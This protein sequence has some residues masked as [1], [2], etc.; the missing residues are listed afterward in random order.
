MGRLAAEAIEAGALGFTT[1]RTVAHRSVDGR[2]TPSLTA[3]APEL[4][5]IARAVGGTG[6]GVFEVVADLVDLDAEFALIRSIAGISGGP[7]PPH[8]PAAP[9]VRA[10]RVPTHPRPHGG[11]GGRRRHDARPG[12]GAPGR[13]DHA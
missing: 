10:R 8:A 3:T 4:L 1:S 5:G 13:P 6:K 7:A 9:R 11:R 2:H 12:R